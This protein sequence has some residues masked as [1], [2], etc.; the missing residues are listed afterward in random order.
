MRLSVAAAALLASACSPSHA[1]VDSDTTDGGGSPLTFPDAAEWDAPLASQV[2]G[3]LH[4]CAGADCHNAGTGGLTLGSGDDFDALIDV[5]S[6]EMP[7]MLRVLPGDPLRS[8]VF[9]KLRC[10]G[11]IAGECM[12]GGVAQPYIARLFHDWI[13]AGAPKE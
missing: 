10:E 12:P 1:S 13:E 6:Q 11:G 3:I 5:P 9:L 8:Y 4:G 7:T 2:S